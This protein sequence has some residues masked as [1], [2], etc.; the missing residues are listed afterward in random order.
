MKDA[1][2][3]KPPFTTAEVDVVEGENETFDPA[4]FHSEFKEFEGFAKRYVF[5]KVKSSSGITSIKY[6]SSIGYCASQYENELKKHL[7]KKLL[8]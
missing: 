4:T 7:N 8:A 6:I 2:F 5:H 3:L 1:N